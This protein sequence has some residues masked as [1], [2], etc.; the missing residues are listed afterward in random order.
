MAAVM[1][2]LAGLPPAIR[3]SSRARMAGLWRVAVRVGM[4]RALRRLARP[5]M[6]MRRP[7]KVPLSRLTGA[8]PTRLAMRRR[9]SLPSS[10]SSAMSVRAEV[11]PMP[12]TEASSSSVSRQAGRRAPRRRDRFRSGRAPSAARLVGL[13]RRT[14]FAC[15]AGGG[16]GSCCRS[17]RRSGGA[18]RP[19][20]RVCACLVRQGRGWVGIASANWAIASASRRSGLASRPVARA[21]SRIWRGLITAKGARRRRARRRRSPRT[22]GRL[23]HDQVR[24]ESEALDERR[25][26]GAVAGDGEASAEGRKCTTADPWRFDADEHRPQRNAPMTRPCE[27]GSP[28]GGPS[29]CWARELQRDGAPNSATGSITPGRNGLPSAAKLAARG[30]LGN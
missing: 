27:S 18:G 15:G 26:P 1:A 6:T 8:T 14:R 29:D 20:R 10:G 24:A 28:V 30:E 5:P 21:K 3:R 4:Y 11:L 13:E 12:G 22:A 23:E 2:T 7:R 25:E 16:A 17:S 9:S 19:A